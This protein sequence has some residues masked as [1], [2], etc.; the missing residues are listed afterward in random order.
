MAVYPSHI[1]NYLIHRLCSIRSYYRKPCFHLIKK[2]LGCFRG[3]VKDGSLLIETS[4]FGISW[5][6]ILLQVAHWSDAKAIFW[7][8]LREYTCRLGPKIL[9]W[10]HSQVH[11]LIKEVLNIFLV[12]IWWDLTNT[13]LYCLIVKTYPFSFLRKSTD[14]A[15]EKC[16]RTSPLDS[17][18]ITNV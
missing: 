12:I 1:A 15:V 17:A 5:F 4:E 2:A 14:N 7:F 16:W 9:N 3:H 18:P 13:V 10:E 8:N 11:F 6:A